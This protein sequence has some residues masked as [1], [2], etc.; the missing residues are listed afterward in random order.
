MASLNHT[1]HWCN[2]VK[3]DQ[4]PSYHKAF[5]SHNQSLVEPSNYS[6]AEKHPLW[7]E[8]MNKELKALDDNNTWDIVDLPPGKKPIGC[9]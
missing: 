6:E 7:V 2:L 5:I 3:Y 4:M 1:P 8:V 9:K